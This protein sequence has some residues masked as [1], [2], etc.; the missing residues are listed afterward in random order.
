MNARQYRRFWW[1]RGARLLEAPE[2]GLSPAMLGWFCALPAAE[3]ERA[4]RARREVVQTMLDHGLDD[5][6][7][8]EID[9]AII[10]SDAA[11]MEE[12]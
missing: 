7:E 8:R 4:E 12:V 6:A 3:A 2:I 10:A 5:D 9:A 1:T 11:C